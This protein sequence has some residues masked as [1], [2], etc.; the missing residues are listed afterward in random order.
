MT[1][2]VHAAAVAFFALWFVATVV[3]QLRTPWAKVVHRRDRF[4]IVP[5]WTFFAPNPGRSDLHVLY[6]DQRAD[7]AFTPWTE[8]GTS[9]VRSRWAPLWNPRKRVGKAVHDAVGAL[10][11]LPRDVGPEVMVSSAY[12]T[13]LTTVCSAERPADARY[14]EF[15]V[16]ATDTTDP[17][18]RPRVR[19][20]SA[21]HPLG[22]ALVR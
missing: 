22:P 11:L 18:A 5:M 4:A 9:A 17:G 12:L 1:G 16:A 8:L 3:K 20:R 13:L 10:A 7:G 2:L 6:R 15:V 14:R 21:L 19:L